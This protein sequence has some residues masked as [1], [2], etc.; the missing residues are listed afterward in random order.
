M[1]EER[2]IALK[3]LEEY[4]SCTFNDLSLLDNALVHRSYV[5]EKQSSLL[6][7]NERLE[8]LGD[9]VLELCISD[10]LDRKSVV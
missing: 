4:I 10:L 6:R 5:N 3:K 8:F 1:T 2:K 9:A 7:D